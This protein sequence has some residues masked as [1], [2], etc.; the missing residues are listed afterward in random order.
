VEALALFQQVDDRFGI[1][2]AR[3]NLAVL[4]IRQG[5]LVAARTHIN[6]ALRL[7]REMHRNGRV[8]H[9]SLYHLG[10][11]ELLDRNVSAARDAFEELLIVSRQMG[12][13]PWVAYSL[14]GLAF[15]ASSTG[16]YERAAGLH[17]AAD[18]LFE[19]LGEALDPDLQSLR[20]RDLGRLRTLHRGDDQFDIAY[21]EGR[22]LKPREAVALAAVE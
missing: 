19:D 21:A 1:A 7:R 22:G 13:R 20:D 17:G 10:L 16:D 6:E 5:D 9:A 15:C 4:A 11:V 18:V 3:Q 8:L 14:L 2:R 12:T